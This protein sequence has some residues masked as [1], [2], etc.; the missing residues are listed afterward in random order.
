M[1]E[2][3]S[4]TITVYKKDAQVCTWSHLSQ[5][6]NSVIKMKKAEFRKLRKSPH[7]IKPKKVNKMLCITFPLLL[8]KMCICI[9]IWMNLHRKSSRRIYSKLIFLND[10]ISGFHFLSSHFCFLNFPL[11]Y[12]TPIILELLKFLMQ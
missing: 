2:K 3:S 9:F 10:A 5:K 12:T 8:K 7:I 1:A 6:E 11:I 4:P